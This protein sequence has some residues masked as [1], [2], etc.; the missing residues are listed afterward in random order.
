MVRVSRGG[1]PAPSPGIPAPSPPGALSATRSR[2][3]ERTG[4]G[5]LAFV[6]AIATAGALAHVEVRLKALEVAYDLGR[7]R[8]IGSELEE[9]RR[10][11]QIEIGMLKD[12]VRVVSIARGQLDMGPPAPEAIHRLGVGPFPR[13][14]APPSVASAKPAP[15]ARAARKTSVR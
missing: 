3:P 9:Q 15:L 5:A 2:S 4:A 8:K 6:L 13:T 1:L 10:R 7:E 11:L 14:A 12:P